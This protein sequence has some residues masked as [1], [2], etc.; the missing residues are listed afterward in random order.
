MIKRIKSR[1][2]QPRA[3][4]FLLFLICSFFAWLVSRL[5]QTY[6][7]N[8]TFGMY[9]ENSPDSLVLLGSPPEELPVRIRAVGFR[10]LQYQLSPKRVGVDLAET[11]KLRG[12]Y[13]IG[14]QVYR[15]QVE[16]QLTDGIA[17][18]EMPSDTLF[19]EFQQLKSRSVP[20]IADLD[21]ELAQNYMMDAEVEVNPPNVHLLGPPGEIDS[22]VS[23]RTRKLNLKDVR[24]SLDREIDLVLPAGL[25]HTNFSTRQVRVRAEVF[26]FSES[27][28]D[29]PVEVV[30]MPANQEVRTF[31]ATV[32]VLCRGRIESLKDLGSEDFRLVADFEDPD[33]QSGRLQ[34]EL[35]RQPANVQSAVPLESS[36][37]FIIRSE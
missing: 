20:V 14:P 11:Q 18:L 28:V 30:N 24:E 1:I 23:I 31:P 29:V 6:T 2:N 3:R 36:V 17:I 12:R 13:F 15:R 8:V 21:L 9:Y 27:V 26:R 7:H 5:S 37:E 25:A 10:I 33:P 4:V 22:I 35:L 34:L 19:F 16:R 32:G